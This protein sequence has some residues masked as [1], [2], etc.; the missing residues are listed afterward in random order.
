M[1]RWRLLQPDSVE[2][3][4][5]RHA[6]KLGL[7]ALCSLAAFA[8]LV[9]VLEPGSFCTL[10]DPPDCNVDSG[11]PGLHFT[12]DN[13]DLARYLVTWGLA[14]WGLMSAAAGALAAHRWTTRAR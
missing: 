5:M 8:L 9:L 10:S 3:V 4:N 13:F 11:I 7:G 14:F 2:P 1:H 6:T 12:T